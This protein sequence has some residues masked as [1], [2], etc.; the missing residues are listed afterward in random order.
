MRQYD[1]DA[2]CRWLAEDETVSA[3]D[4]EQVCRH[5]GSARVVVRQLLAVI[6]DLQQEQGQ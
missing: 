2:A 6:A 3:S 4:R 5:L 1:I